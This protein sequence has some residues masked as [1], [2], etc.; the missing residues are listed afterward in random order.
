MRKSLLQKLLLF[1]D[2]KSRCIIDF[3]KSIKDM[4]YM[5]IATWEDIEE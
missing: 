3:V 2:V 4:A 1:E 5:T